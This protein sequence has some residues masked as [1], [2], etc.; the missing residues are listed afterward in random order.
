MKKKFM[1]VI[2]LVSLM[3]GS[4]VVGA[5]GSSLLGA[6]VQGLFSVEVNGKKIEDA[7]VLNGSTYAPVRSISES[8]GAE[9]AVNGKKVVITTDVDKDIQTNGKIYELDTQIAS[10]NKEL[11]NLK[12]YLKASEESLEINA[13][14]DMYKVT[15]VK[16]EDTETYKAT[17]EKN[18]N[19][20]SDI[21]KLT[22][23]IAELEAKKQQLEK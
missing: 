4:A 18:K 9:I 20:Q 22:K 3:G 2:L 14:S 17:T 6:K 10:K 8:L 23:E 1:T 13:A 7:V 19:Y 12:E 16:F 11:G 15:G 21:D 5:A